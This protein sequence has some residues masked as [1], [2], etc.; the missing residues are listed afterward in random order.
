MSLDY[1]LTSRPTILAHCFVDCPHA[2]QG[3]ADGAAE[4]SSS[5]FGLPCEYPSGQLAASRELYAVCGKGQVP[6][7]GLE[8]AAGE[9]GEGGGRVDA[10]VVVS[11]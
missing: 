9:C 11:V 7:R 3:Q 8:E 6:R 1:E 4:E 2:V 10:A 5:Y